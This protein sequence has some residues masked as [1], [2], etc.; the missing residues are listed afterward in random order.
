MRKEIKKL[1][2]EYEKY[3]KENGICLNPDKKVVE[4][5][6][7]GILEKEK[8]YGKRYCPCR[9]ITG[10]KE[11]DKKIICPCVYCKEEI[12]KYGHCH[13]FLFVRCRRKKMKFLIIKVEPR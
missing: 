13:C 9:R 7:N 2:K 4:F 6:L 1:L 5:L 11:K 10:D 8:K 12:K 3:A